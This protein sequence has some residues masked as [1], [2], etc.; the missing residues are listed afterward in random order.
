MKNN[1]NNLTSVS[2]AKRNRHDDGSKISIMANNIAV[3]RVTA[4]KLHTYQDKHD[5]MLYNTIINLMDA[6][7]H[8]AND[9]FTVDGKLYNFTASGYEAVLKSFDTIRRKLEEAQT[10]SEKLPGM[11]AAYTK[12]IS[13]VL[14][15]NTE[16]VTN[17]NATNTE[18]G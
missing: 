2:A 17:V 7:N 4:E 15:I 8:N 11:E 16:D 10:A 1:N 3:T 6:P 5:N 9:T 14:G 13:E 12:L 18:E